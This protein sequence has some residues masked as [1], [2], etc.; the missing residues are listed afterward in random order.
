MLLS[1]ALAVAE[2]WTR[3]GLSR[4]VPRLPPVFAILATVSAVYAATLLLMRRPRIAPAMRGPT[5]EHLTGV[6]APVPHAAA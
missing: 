2:M 1:A 3:L 5:A 4:A 6:P